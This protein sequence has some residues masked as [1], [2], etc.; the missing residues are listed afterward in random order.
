MPESRQAA[1]GVRTRSGKSSLRSRTA[2]AAALIAVVIGALTLA[3]AC[4][5]ER[6][7]GSARGNGG[8]GSRKGE[9]GDGAP[10]ASH[11]P[12]P[13]GQATHRS[14]SP[15]PS[16]ASLWN[17]HPHSLAAVGDSIT[18]GFDAC[19]LL[20]DC[21][22]ASWATGDDGAVNSLARRL[23]GGAPP[24]R[25]WNYAA[26]GSVMADLPA[27]MSRAARRNPE[28]VTVLAGANDACRSTATRMTPVDDFR[29]SFVRA[30]HTLR[31]ERPR[32]EV[33]VSSVPDLR[34]LWSLGRRDPLGERIWKLGIC[35]SML[36]HPQS[37]S[38]SARDRRQE[39]YDR[40]VA[41]NSVLR[42]ECAKV[43][44]CRYDDGA[45]FNFRFTK[46]E[47]SHW[48][49]FHP[50]KPGQRKLAELA[51]ERITAPRWRRPGA[52]GGGHG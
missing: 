25:G 26:S 40:V 14:P 17:R 35:Q 20:A 8:D 33:Y 43:R 9:G 24:G 50:S 23:A 29:G 45:V 46:A 12:G 36:R 32:A 22:R 4:G 2:A 15:S 38:L 28:L 37:M 16:S 1:Q 39:V 48:D 31:R 10:T 41:Y 19:S 47:L 5:A 52:S 44:R 13:G 11:V 6:H 30:L 18:R 27:Q 7:D 49:W 21:P 34:R 3:V 42:E 51:Y